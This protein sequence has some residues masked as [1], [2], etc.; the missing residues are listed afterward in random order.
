MTAFP[1]LFSQLMIGQSAALQQ[2]FRQMAQAA[3]SD[4]TVCLQGPSGVGKELVARAIH[5]VSGRRLRPLV[6]VNCGAI[7]ENLVES[8]LFGHVK[9]AFTGATDDRAGKF[10]DANGGTL[11]LDEIGELTPAAQ[12]RLL[13]VLQERVVERVGG[14]TSEKVDIRLICATHRDLQNMVKEG[15]FREDLFYRIHVLPLQLP[16]L[17]ERREDIPLLVEHFLEKFCAL[18]QLPRKHLTPM[19]LQALQNFT[20]P[21]NIRQLENAIH[22]AV[23]AIPGTPIDVGDIPL[24]KPDA[25]VAIVADWRLDSVEAAHIQ[26]ALQHVR[27]NMSK[28]AQLLGISRATLYRKCKTYHLLEI[29]P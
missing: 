23:V 11:F 7:P 13:R 4:I 17:Q 1:P 28:A 16:T 2:L 8:I 12:V 20:W 5:G 9:G 6:T 27:G 21:G 19:A 14:A 26:R 25:P 24:H 18:E 3:K 15:K 10:H 29:T 22:R